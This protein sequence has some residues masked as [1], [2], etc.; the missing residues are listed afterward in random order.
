VF[1]IIQT[2]MP[3]NLSGHLGPQQNADV[4]AYILKR[5]GS[6]VGLEELPRRSELLST[7]TILAKRP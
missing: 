3:W 1:D 6:P 5:S 4:L 2:R 7:M